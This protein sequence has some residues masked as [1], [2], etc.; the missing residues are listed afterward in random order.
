MLLSG[1][2]S[3][4]ISFKGTGAKRNCSFHSWAHEHK[5]RLLVFTEHFKIKLVC[6]AAWF[7]RTQ[8][9]TQHTDDRFVQFSESPAAVC[10]AVSPW[11][12]TRVYTAQAGSSVYTSQVLGL[13]L[14]TRCLPR[15]SL[16][17]TT[18]LKYTLIFLGMKRLSL[19]SV[20]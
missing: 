3:N 11:A 13:P 19:E 17:S 8:G 10:G 14:P 1:R 16:F 18:N 2:N 4:F 12:E 6:G 15:T 20:T 9:T 7:H 5:C